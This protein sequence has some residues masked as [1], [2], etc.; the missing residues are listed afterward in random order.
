MSRRWTEEELKILEKLRFMM[1]IRRIA[2]KLNRTPC[3]VQSKLCRI[4]K[5]SYPYLTTLYTVQDVCEHAGVHKETIFRAIKSG[6]IVPAKVLDSKPA[7]YFCEKQLQEIRG[8]FKKKV[9]LTEYEKQQIKFMH[10]VKQMRTVDIAIKLNKPYSTVDNI[11]NG[12]SERCRAKR[13]AARNL[14]DSKTI[15][16]KSEAY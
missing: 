8:M 7:Y 15:P 6:K 9:R 4:G 5:R 12:Y 14:S 10:N 13:E 1:P 11:V 2:K 16:Q 3:S